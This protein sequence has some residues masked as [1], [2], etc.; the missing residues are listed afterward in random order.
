MASMES[1]YNT[2]QPYIQDFIDVVLSFTPEEQEKLLLFVTGQ[3][4]LD[5]QFPFI[6]NHLVAKSFA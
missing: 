4:K 6:F 5:V 3:R 2:D 1:R